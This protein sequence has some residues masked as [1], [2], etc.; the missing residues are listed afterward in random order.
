MAL[1]V[2]GYP[3]KLF[4]HLSKTHTLHHSVDMPDIDLK[5][6]GVGVVAKK[7]GAKNLMLYHLVPAMDYDTEGRVFDI[8][9]EDWAKAPSKEFGKRVI[10]GKDL[11]RVDSLN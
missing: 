4:K 9:P 5:A 8:A 1:A 10:V 11:L 2:G 7:A 3:P 6:D